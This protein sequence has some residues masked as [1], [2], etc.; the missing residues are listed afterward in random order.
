MI[1]SISYIILDISLRVGQET[2]T[3]WRTLREPPLSASGS[4]YGSS[5][6]DSYKHS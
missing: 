3:M 2:E 1:N 6:T 5:Y 4:E